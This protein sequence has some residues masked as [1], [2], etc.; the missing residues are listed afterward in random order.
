MTA[1]PS[2]DLL[3]RTKKQMEAALEAAKREST[4]IR[5]GR[6]NPS[7]L[8]RVM[9]EYYGDMV[10]V[11]HIA[12][13]TAPEPRLLV[14]KPF[15]PSTTPAV[16]KALQGSDL[17][18]NPL[19]EA[20]IIRLPLPVLTEERRRELVKEVHKKTE[21]KKVEVRNSRREAIDE[22]RKLEKTHKIS[23]DELRYFQEQVQKL[24][25]AHIQ[26]LEELQE[27]KEEELLEV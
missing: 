17:G 4:A 16:R 20:D 13:V 24:T 15:D 12:T 21:E 26:E 18:V 7:L 2:K 14:I 5:T 25:D 3:K 27:K 11:R 1:D 10:P 19:V 9:V 8:D 23:E 22:M 6:A